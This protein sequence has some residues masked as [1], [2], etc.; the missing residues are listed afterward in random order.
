MKHSIGWVL[1]EEIA[2]NNFLD[3]DKAHIV[4]SNEWDL[5]VMSMSENEMENTFEVSLEVFNLLE[6]S[7]CKSRFGTSTPPGFRT[8]LTPSTISNATRFN[9]CRITESIQ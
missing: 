8:D 5:D 2:E 4:R 7:V 3:T 1:P 6:V 9:R